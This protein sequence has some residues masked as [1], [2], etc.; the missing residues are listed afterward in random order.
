MTSV[1]I[2]LEIIDFLPNTFNFS[3]FGF[4]FKC[5]NLENEITFLEHNQ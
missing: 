5:E 1:I 2:S 4:I 3:D